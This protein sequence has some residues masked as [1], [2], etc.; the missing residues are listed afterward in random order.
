[1]IRHITMSTAPVVYVCRLV[2]VVAAG[3]SATFVLWL[4]EVSGSIVEELHGGSGTTNAM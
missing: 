1:M 3:R 2:G 4:E